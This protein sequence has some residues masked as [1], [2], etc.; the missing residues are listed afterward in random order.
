[1]K[2]QMKAFISNFYTKLYAFKE[3]IKE[4]FQHPNWRDFLLQLNSPPFVLED[5]RS[6]TKCI[7]KM[8]SVLS[9]NPDYVIKSTQVVK[10]VHTCKL[11]DL[12]L[13]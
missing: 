9:D 5:I 10:E 4:N 12:W 3:K 7:F 2:N 6:G 1:M 11:L 8:R 13:V